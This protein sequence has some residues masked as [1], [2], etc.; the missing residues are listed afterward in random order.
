MK[1]GEKMKIGLVLAGGGGKG[2]YQIGVM[3]ALHQLDLLKKIEGVAGTSVG[4]LNAA[5]FLNEDIHVAERMWETISPSKILSL[6]S[7][8]LSTNNLFA[9]SNYIQK[10]KKYS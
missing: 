7:P 4:A 10:F 5:L 8:L 3:K 6:K 9:S 1:L 2:S